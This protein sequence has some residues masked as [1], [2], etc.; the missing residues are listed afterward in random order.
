MVVRILIEQVARQVG[1]GLRRLP[2]LG[3]LDLV[4][5]GVKLGYVAER[6]AEQAKPFGGAGGSGNVDL[7]PVDANIKPAIV[8]GYAER[9]GLIGAHGCER[10]TSRQALTSELAPRPR[11]AFP[12]SATPLEM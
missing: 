12:G 9:L 1:P 11:L 2:R 7:G 10:R 3:G 5:G 4:A 8:L 6:D